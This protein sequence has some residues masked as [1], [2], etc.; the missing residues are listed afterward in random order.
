MATSIVGT[1]IKYNDLILLLNY[2]EEK[3]ESGGLKNAFI[4]F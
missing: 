3:R 2:C 1:L 4:F